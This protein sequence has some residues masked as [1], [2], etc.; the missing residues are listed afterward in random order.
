MQRFEIGILF[1]GE[2]DIWGQPVIDSL[3][4][5][6][7]VHQDQS[8]KTYFRACFVRYYA[9]NVNARGERRGQGRARSVCCVLRPP[10]FCCPAIPKRGQ[11]SLPS[12]RSNAT[13]V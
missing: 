2:I 9:R 11:V 10:L 12:P 3:D 5:L 8:P 13:R 7:R 6:K 1:D 4:R